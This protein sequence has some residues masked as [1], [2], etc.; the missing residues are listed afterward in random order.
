M[1]IE[2]G[3]GAFIW[4]RPIETRKNKSRLRSKT[5]VGSGNGLVR[6]TQGETSQQ[7]GTERKD[8]Y[9]NSSIV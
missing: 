3:E 1:S 7:T 2:G 4:K 8:P 5:K 9:A 6:L